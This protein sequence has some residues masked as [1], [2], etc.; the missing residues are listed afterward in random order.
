MRRL[1][2]GGENRLA[3]AIRLFGYAIDVYESEPGAHARFAR[4]LE[5]GRRFG[6]TR[7]MRLGC[8]LAIGALVEANALRRGEAGASYATAMKLAK[9]SLESPPYMVSAAYR[10]M[11]YAED[12]RGRPERAVELLQR[13]EREALERDQPVD[14]AI[15]RY[16]L[17]LRLSGDEGARMVSAARTDA[18]A[19]GAS[20]STL[21]DDV[22]RR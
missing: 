10:A 1:E 9:R 16:Q 18:L 2:A 14:R 15:A 13:A 11:A 21:K 17:G 4:D 7:Y 12:A 8:V 3:H 6:A 5:A 20:E 19:A 22:V